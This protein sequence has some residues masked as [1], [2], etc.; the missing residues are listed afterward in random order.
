MNDKEYI[1]YLRNIVGHQKIISVGLAVILIDKKGRVL[2]EKRSDNGKYCLPGGSINFDE[3][4][5][6][7][8][9]RE[10]KEETNLE[11]KNPGLLMI[12]SGKKEEFVYPNGDVTDYVD[13]IF[14]EKAEEEMEDL[15]KHD[16]ESTELSF[17][18]LDQLPDESLMLRGTLRPLKKVMS[19]DFSLEID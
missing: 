6:E 13:L 10:V 14:Y 1:P 19:G 15:L 17:Y 5:V 18:S 2:L 7:G 3:T 12:L 8:L 11:L 4:V 9:K 16:S